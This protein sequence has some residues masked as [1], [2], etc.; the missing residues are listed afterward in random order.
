MQC[1][2]CKYPYSK[3]VYTRRNE[4]QSLS[5]RRHECLRCGWRF[6]TQE[7]LKVPR[8]NDDRFPKGS[9]E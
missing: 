2:N 1:S 9:H 6:T 7:K 3:V 4:E 8:V 5:N